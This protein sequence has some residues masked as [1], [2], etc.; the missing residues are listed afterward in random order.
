M[1]LLQ[2]RSKG[3]QIFIIEYYQTC[4]QDFE[5]TFYQGVGLFGVC[6][7]MHVSLQLRRALI[8]MA[9]QMQLQEQQ[10]SI[11]RQLHAI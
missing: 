2:S 10:H 4:I 5:L 9:H 3:F 8:R 1:Y 11:Q 7:C 6:V